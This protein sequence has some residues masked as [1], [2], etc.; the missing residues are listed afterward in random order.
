MCLPPYI[1]YVNV[2]VNDYALLQAQPSPTT[3]KLPYLMATDANSTMPAAAKMNGDRT[4][5]DDVF[6]FQPHL[7]PKVPSSSY[8]EK[9]IF[10]TFRFLLFFA[11]LVAAFYCQKNN[12]SHFSMH[13]YPYFF[14]MSYRVT[15]PATKTSHYQIFISR[16]PVFSQALL[17]S[18][19]LLMKQLLNQRHLTPCS[20]IINLLLKSRK[21]VTQ[22][23]ME[24]TLLPQLAP[25]PRMDITGENM[26]KSKL[27]AVNI[28]GATTN[29][30]TQ[31]AL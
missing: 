1:R 3:G 4:F 5:S 13:L 28:L 19:T 16:N 9:V 17:Q 8:V 25:Q 12:L 29:V 22:T 23:K 15:M 26:D 7:G 31:I 18:R 10:L 21:M 11:V 20:V 24:N 27:R 14:S 6:S 30:H 2:A